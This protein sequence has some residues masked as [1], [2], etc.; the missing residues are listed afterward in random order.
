MVLDRELTWSRGVRRQRWRWLLAFFIS[1][2]F[3]LP[4][5][6]KVGG[7]RRFMKMDSS[8]YAYTLEFNRT[9]YATPLGLCAMSARVD[10]APAFFDPAVASRQ[11]V[12]DG[13][14]VER[15]VF[16]AILE[17]SSLQDYHFLAIGGKLS[18]VRWFCGALTGSVVLLVLSP[19]IFVI[20]WN[21]FI[22]FMHSRRK[23][24]G[25]GPR[26]DRCGYCLKGLQGRPCPECGCAR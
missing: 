7:T 1:C 2:S 8:P 12:P 20:G 6:S 3:F 13:D 19:V 16:Y 23:P 18:G 21:M 5:E 10:I 11:E 15:R 22:Q 4:R 17:D 24:Q 14:V 25:Q 9:Q 26:C